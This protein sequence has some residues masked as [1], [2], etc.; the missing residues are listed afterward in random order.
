MSFDLRK[1]LNPLNWS[2]VAR[3]LAMPVATA[4]LPIFVVACTAHKAVCV[5]DVSS[6]AE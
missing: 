6:V 2:I 4:L 5:Y 1:L 3:L